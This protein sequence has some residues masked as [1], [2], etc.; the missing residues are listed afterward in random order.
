MDFREFLKIPAERQ[1]TKEKA[2]TFVEGEKRRAGERKS[3]KAK[4]KGRTGIPFGTRIR[5]MATDGRGS[6]SCPRKGRRRGKG[7]DGPRM[8]RKGWE[9]PRKGREWAR[10]P[11]WLRMGRMVPGPGLRI[12]SCPSRHFFSLGEGFSRKGSPAGNGQPKLKKPRKKR[13]RGKFTFFSISNEKQKDRKTLQSPR[14]K[15]MARK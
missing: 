3:E 12:R 11:S 14:R 10:E 15:K 7:A 2:K 13:A 5:P 4:E 6:R 1:K 9:V 8:G